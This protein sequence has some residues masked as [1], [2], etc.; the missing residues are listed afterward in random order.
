MRTRLGIDVFNVEG[1][2]MALG[3]R[4]VFCQL[5]FVCGCYDDLLKHPHYW[6]S[7]ERE[8]ERERE[9]ECVC[10]FPDY[11]CVYVVNGWRDGL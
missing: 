2:P 10:V 8:R 1:F 3:S 11:I 7:W 9:R 5:K 4:L 6:E